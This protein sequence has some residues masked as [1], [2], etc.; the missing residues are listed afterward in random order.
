MRAIKYLF[1]ATLA[2]MLASCS[3]YKEITIDKMTNLKV[4]E[5][6]GSTAIV[7]LKLL[8]NNPTGSAVSLK[9]IDIDLN[10]KNAKF[11]HVTS[12][13]KVVVPA[14]THEEHTVSLMI[15]ITN[16]LSSGA[17]LLS[18]KLNPEDF[19]ANGYIKVSKFPFSKK[20]R[21][22]NQNI[23]DILKGISSVRGTNT[24]K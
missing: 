1:L 22:N 15:R 6:Q 13:E 4:R 18:G 8:I 21:L 24:A 10:R 20:I 9:E 17:V 12:I 16:I 14:K 7:D 2:I 23:N 11:A 3:S 5:F 19:T